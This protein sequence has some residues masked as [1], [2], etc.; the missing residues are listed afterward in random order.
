MIFIASLFI[1]P[2]LRY[3]LPVIQNSYLPTLDW[4]AFKTA[5]HRQP[6]L[7]YVG[8]IFL[9]SSAINVSHFQYT[10]TSNILYVKFIKTVL[11]LKVLTQVSAL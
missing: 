3:P 5:N 7:D 4:K 9:Q 6:S 2:E 1:N 11:K 8:I 10:M